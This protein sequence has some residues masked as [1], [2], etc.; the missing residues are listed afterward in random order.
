MNNTNPDEK[1]MI[2]G[3]EQQT[4]EIISIIENKYNL[5]AG[6]SNNLLPNSI[7]IS[8]PSGTGKT[9]L[10]EYI[11]KRFESKIRFI[12]IYTLID[13]NI[14]FLNINKPTVFIID[15]LDRLNELGFTEQD[16][17]F[18]IKNFSNFNN[19]SSL[20][21]GAGDATKIYPQLNEFFEKAVQIPLPNKESRENILKFYLNPNVSDLSHLNIETIVK[22]TAG[23]SGA[24]IIKICKQ[25]YQKS[26]YSKDHLLATED[27][28]KAIA[29]YNTGV[30][31]NETNNYTWNSLGGMKE[32]IENIQ[33][34]IL[35]PLEYE[36][37]FK[38]YNI[39]LPKGILLYG[40]P[41]TGKT[42]IAKILANQS[43]FS[44]FSFSGSDILGKY[45]GESEKNIKNYFKKAKENAPSILFIDEIENLGSKRDN[46]INS[47]IYNSL[48]DELLH[49]MDG[50]NEL[51]NV[52]V[53]GATNV[54][55]LLDP[56]L[57]RSGRFDRKYEIPLPDLEGRKEIFEIYIN[58]FNL[59]SKLKEN[60]GNKEEFISHIAENANGFSGADIENL[61]SHVAS[62]IV[63]KKI[64]KDK[65]KTN[66]T[67][68]EPILQIFNRLMF[69]NRIKDEKHN[70]IGFIKSKDK[71]ITELRS[72]LRKPI[73]ILKLKNNK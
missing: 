39:S 71:D 37:Y 42:T 64:I 36:E 53:I 50:I 59:S 58:K 56:A 49:Q 15:Q 60:N 35:L 33:K 44:F 63:Y 65:N 24:E 8:G 9:T 10:L 72:Q 12:D 68:T 14:T 17:P 29:K 40:P 23:L 28:I 31:D 61:C 25:A 34:D 46:D 27:F 70:E 54:H 69:K 47:K 26:L 45:V 4:N 57:L 51:K 2:Y 21:I 73:S 18:F 48:I 5:S 19:K 30:K 13:N 38:E 11:K 43:G 1:Y 55:E 66:E 3:A 22:S 7:L 32:I 41:G 52:I 16:V 6:A 20:I 67:E 62:E